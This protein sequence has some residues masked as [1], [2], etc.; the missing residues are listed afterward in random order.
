MMAGREAEKRSWLSWAGSTPAAHANKETA[1]ASEL[2]QARPAK[3]NGRNS[4]LTTN[5]SL[6]SMM[7]LPTGAP[8]AVMS[9][10]T[11]VVAI[12]VV[13][14]GEMFLRVSFTE[15]GLS[16]G[17]GVRQQLHKPAQ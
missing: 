17:S 1:A 13:G 10:K 9:K 4:K 2:D 11:L 8:S 5:N 3:S 12:V 6:T 7:I 14:V 16:A 15:V